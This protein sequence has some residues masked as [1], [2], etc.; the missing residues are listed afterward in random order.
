MGIHTV[1][2]KFAVLGTLTAACSAMVVLTYVPARTQTALRQATVSAVRSSIM[3]AADVGVATTNASQGRRVAPATIGEAVAMT[4]TELS[5]CDIAAINLLCAADL[6]G[7][8]VIDP[9][10]ALRTLDL[11]ASFV[12]AETERLMPVF[13]RDPSV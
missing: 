12:R 4:D 10:R 2:F 11:W 9:A 6:C 13:R 3:S 5:E 7:S 8:E 1:K